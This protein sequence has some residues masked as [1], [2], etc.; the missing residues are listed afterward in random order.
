MKEVTFKNMKCKTG[1]LIPRKGDARDSMSFDKYELERIKGIQEERFKDN[2]RGFTR[3]KVIFKILKNRNIDK[4]NMTKGQRGGRHF[5]EEFDTTGMDSV[6]LAIKIPRKMN[7][8]SRLPDSSQAI[9][10]PQ[11]LSKFL[12]YI[13]ARDMLDK[14]NRTKLPIRKRLE[15][16]PQ[17]SGS[18]DAT[19]AEI[20][21]AIPT[22][23]NHNPGYAYPNYR[24]GSGTQFQ[25]PEGYV[26]RT[27]E[28]WSPSK[29]VL[30]IFLVCILRMWDVTS[31]EDIIPKRRNS[32]KDRL[33]KV[34]QPRGP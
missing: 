9:C 23:T 31:G 2:L 10:N 5:K 4:G 21:I 30:M 18:V 3:R 33:R 12:R 28:A 17:F 14:M 1:G 29:S 32:S 11:S 8:D 7:D 27:S 20:S 13:G 26:P 19:V 34:P 24:K 22:R 6:W 25:A 15:N 16:V